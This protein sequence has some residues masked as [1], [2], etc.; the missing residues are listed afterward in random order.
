MNKDKLMSLIRKLFNLGSK[1][2]NPNQA[3]AELAMEKAKTLMAKHQIKMSEIS[4]NDP[5]QNNYNEQEGFEKRV[6]RAWDKR[7][8]QAVAKVCLCNIFTTYGIG[9]KGRT[10][11]KIIF[12]GLEMDTAVAKELYI[13]LR[14][15]LNRMARDAYNDKP[16][17]RAYML[18]VASGLYMKATTAVK[19]LKPKAAE[20]Y[21]ALVAVKDHALSMAWK[22]ICAKRNLKPGKSRQRKVRLSYFHGQVDSK[23]VS[24]QSRRTLK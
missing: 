14:K 15:T 5:T 17:Q 21:G 6:L 9:A 19:D 22:D 4:M 16:N 12:F 13:E 3:E 2:K 11:E 1:D 20:Q 23:K 8:A 24:L 7:L 10:V 18:G